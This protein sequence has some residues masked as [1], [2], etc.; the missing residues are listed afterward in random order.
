MLSDNHPS[1]QPPRWG[2]YDDIRLSEMVERFG[3]E[4]VIKRLVIII[5]NVIEDKN[6]TD[7]RRAEAK[8]MLAV[9][10]RGGLSRE[11]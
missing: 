11:L 9:L 7:A 4:M 1:N 5:Y 8:R 10:K 3:A 6:A 2:V